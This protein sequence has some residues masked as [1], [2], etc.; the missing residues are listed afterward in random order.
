MLVARTRPG[1]RVAANSRP[2]S[3]RPRTAPRPGPRRRFPLQRLG[4]RR[5][6]TT[7]S[8]RGA[9]VYLRNRYYDP[10]TGQF[11]TRDPL[12]AQTGQPYSYTGDDPLN[13][14]DPSG[15]CGVGG[16]LDGDCEARAVYNN[17]I[18]PAYQDVLNPAYDWSVE[19]LDPVYYVLPY[20]YNEAQSYEN[21]CGY[22]QSVTYGLEG[23]GVAAAETAAGWGLGKLAG[24]AIGSLAD[25]LGGS[26]VFGRIFGLGFHL[27]FD[28]DPHPFP[29]IGNSPH[30]Q[31][32][33]WRPG[34]SG[35]GHSF[36]IPWPF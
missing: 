21:G 3:T 15:L 27:H 35:S 24:W 22:W 25:A 32:D 7:G 8:C 26:G 31:G 20:Y 30:F 17:L 2:G 4:V 14:T 18:D 9:S 1:R 28:T 10:A 6:V 19:H 11:L 16:W 12:E 29:L 13:A 34:V 33:I 5:P 23:T 36:R